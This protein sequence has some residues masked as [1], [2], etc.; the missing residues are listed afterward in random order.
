MHP[1]LDAEHPPDWEGPTHQIAHRDIS[2]HAG[3]RF[4]TTVRFYHREFA[5]A[6]ATRLSGCASRF[7][8]SSISIPVSLPVHLPVAFAFSGTRV[9]RGKGTG[10]EYG[11]A[12]IERRAQ[13]QFLS[14]AARAFLAWTN[15]LMQSPTNAAHITAIAA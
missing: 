6:I 12:K 13:S 8:H 2:T 7:W 4:L 1:H 14:P 15:E 10:T 3:L 11:W 9:G 5:R